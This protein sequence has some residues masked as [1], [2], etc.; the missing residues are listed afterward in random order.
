MEYNSA[1]L[2]DDELRTGELLLIFFYQVPELIKKYVVLISGL[3][4][5]H[6]KIAYTTHLSLVKF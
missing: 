1:E 4:L 5:F 3:L 2:L 6:A